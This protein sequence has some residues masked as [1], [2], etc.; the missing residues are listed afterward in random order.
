MNKFGMFTAAVLTASGLALGATGIASAEPAQPPVS[1]GSAPGLPLLLGQLLSGSASAPKPTGAEAVATE[2]GSAS[3][4]SL[5]GGLS[6]T[7]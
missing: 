7:K 2:T 6:G 4:S 5:S 1:T 3:G